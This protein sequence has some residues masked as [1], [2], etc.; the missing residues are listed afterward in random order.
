MVWNGAISQAEAA[1]IERVQKCALHIFLG[2]KYASYKEA[3]G[4]TNLQ[5]LGIRREELCLNFARKAVKNPKHK[6]WFKPTMPS[7]TRQS[8]KTYCDAIARTGRLQKSPIPYLTNLL[9]KK[10]K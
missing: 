5:M 3:L 8:Q 9:N 7:K 2:D 1:D 10:L 4:T 6:E